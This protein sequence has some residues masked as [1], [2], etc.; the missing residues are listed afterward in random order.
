MNIPPMRQSDMIRKLYA[1]HAGDKPAVCAA[2]VR[3]HDDGLVVRKSN[4]T[5]QTIERYAD[6]LFRNGMRR[7]WFA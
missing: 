5:G 2:F 7:G 4:K 1:E 3:A 6:A